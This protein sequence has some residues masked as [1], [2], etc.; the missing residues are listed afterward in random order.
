MDRVFYACDSSCSNDIFHSSSPN[1]QLP[2]L[3][4][5]HL[6]RSMHALGAACLGDVANVGMVGQVLRNQDPV[7]APAQGEKRISSA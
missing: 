5:Q 2:I 4:H 3:R 1:T 6:P 7:S